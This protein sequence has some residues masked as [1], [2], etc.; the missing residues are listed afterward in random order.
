MEKSCV[1]NYS[2][3]LI[4]NGLIFSSV[5]DLNSNSNIEKNVKFIILSILFLLMSMGTF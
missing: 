4:R 1:K 3:I 5:H 2:N